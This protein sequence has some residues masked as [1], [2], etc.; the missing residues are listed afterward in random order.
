MPWRY[1][2][3]NSNTSA[4]EPPSSSKSPIA[5]LGTLFCLKFYNKLSYPS[6]IPLFLM[7][8]LM[9]LKSLWWFNS[10]LAFSYSSYSSFSNY[11][12][13]SAFTFNASLTNSTVCRGSDSFFCDGFGTRYSGA[14]CVLSSGWNFHLSEMS[15]YNYFTSFDII[16][17]QIN[18][19]V[20]NQYNILQLIQ[21]IFI[22]SLI[23]I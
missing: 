16:V 22:Y 1:H 17:N 4:V 5:S 6:K 3:A 23:S 10:S 2:A 12:L 19:N 9:Y 14:G 8:S 20:N 18:I 7:A 15:L 11:L 21:L 13:A